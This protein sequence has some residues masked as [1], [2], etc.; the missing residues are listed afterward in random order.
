M[1]GRGREYG[2]MIVSTVC[3]VPTAPAARAR[4]PLP[5]NPILR[6]LH[7]H[8]SA[9]DGTQERRVKKQPIRNPHV[10]GVVFAAHTITTL[11]MGVG[12]NRRKKGRSKKKS[13]NSSPAAD[14]TII[15]SML[16]CAVYGT[17]DTTSQAQQQILRTC[18]NTMYNVLH[19]HVLT[20]FE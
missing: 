12:N 18:A 9:R 16:D 4:H 14:S 13:P 20:M 2:G 7:T 15:S 5:P 10:R 1:G 6:L 17:T 8:T 3:R 19:V 11:I